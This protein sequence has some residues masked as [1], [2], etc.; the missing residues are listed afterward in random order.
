MLTGRL[1]LMHTHAYACMGKE[2]HRHTSICRQTDGDGHIH[3][4]ARLSK[5]WLLG[6]T[7]QWFWLPVK[8]KQ[9]E[10]L[11]PKKCI[12][13]QSHMCLA[14][15]LYHVSALALWKLEK[16]RSAWREME[17]QQESGSEWRIG[18]FLWRRRLQLFCHEGYLAHS[19]FTCIQ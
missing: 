16:F 6:R 14:L 18:R 1:H 7:P 5:H 8:G 13:D 11:W 2:S 4:R 12:L 17:E 10:L 3:A 15:H 9:H 19:D